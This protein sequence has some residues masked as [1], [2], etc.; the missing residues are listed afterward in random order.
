MASTF[1]KTDGDLRAV[2]DTMFKSREFFSA[3][4]WQAKLKSPLEFV[5]SAVRALDGDAADTFSLTKRIAELGQPLYGKAEPT[6]YPNTGEGWASTV[7][8]LGRINFASALVEGR[9]PGVQTPLKRFD[10]KPTAAIVSEL[11]GT[12][13]SKET[14]TAIEIGLQNIQSNRATVASLAIASP[15]FQRR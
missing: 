2:L 5:A 8:L 9:V 13:V 12:T 4:S 14:L 10:D 7:G 11:L 6:G 3:G 1:V 15:D